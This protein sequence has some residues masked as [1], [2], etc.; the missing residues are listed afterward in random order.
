MGVG[1]STVRV[2]PPE[3]AGGAD[4]ST[5]PATKGRQ[6]GIRSWK[7][8]RMGMHRE[9]LRQHFPANQSRIALQTRGILTEVV[10][11]RTAGFVLD[12]LG[13]PLPL[14]ARGA[15]FRPC[16][17]EGEVN[18]ARNSSHKAPDHDDERAFEPGPA[19]TQGERVEVEVVECGCAQLRVHRV[20]PGLMVLA[21]V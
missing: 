4:A 12:R 14:A 8:W 5:D 13:S 11:S 15:G 1:A 2:S 16:W 21:V 18:R 7:L 3:R 19:L 17:F 10:S 20:P 9:W 6:A